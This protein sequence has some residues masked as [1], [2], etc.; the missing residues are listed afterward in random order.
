MSLN[1]R[2]KQI[3]PKVTIDQKEDNISTGKKLKGVFSGIFG[4]F[5]KKRLFL[6]SILLIFTF[7]ILK[8]YPDIKNLSNLSILDES[9]IMDQEKKIFEIENKIVSNKEKLDLLEDKNEAL[10]NLQAKILEL[11]TEI[12]EIS[13]KNNLITQQNNELIDYIELI[14]EKPKDAEIII[15]E[16]K[17]IQKVQLGYDE[18]IFYEQ[19]QN[20]D[21]VYE[22]KI[23]TEAVNESPINTSIDNEKNNLVAL[24]INKI[25]EN[26]RVKE[27]FDDE[28][29]LLL[30]LELDYEN[31]DN[32]KNISNN[33]IPTPEEIISELDNY[34]KENI[35]LYQGENKIKSKFF[36]ILSKEVNVARV[37]YRDASLIEELRYN[38][39]KDDLTDAKV[40][41]SKLEIRDEL[42]DISEK[43]ELRTVYLNELSNLKLRFENN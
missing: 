23:N 21:F 28:V 20:K 13:E 35:N 19:Q 36:D 12:Q 25:E 18:E 24:I 32:L 34:L 31:I 41:L 4:F 22:K 6:L 2:K 7:G 9:F 15:E 8:Y 40:I 27:N 11:N 42:I 26:V 16:P 3:K 17:E 33:L 14:R 30:S 10:L 38:I 37:N 43:L 29:E 39:Y 5:S 1:T